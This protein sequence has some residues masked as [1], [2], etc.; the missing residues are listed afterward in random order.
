MAGIETIRYSLRNLMHR[1]ARSFLTVLSIFIGIATIFIFISFGLGLF[2]YINDMLMGSSAN[3]IIVQGKGFAAP[4]LDA[5]FKLDD[6]DLRAVENS[7]GVVEASGVYFKVAEVEFA[8][9]K[10]YAFV[11]GYDPKKPIIMDV[12]NVDIDEGRELN[13]GDNNKV[14]LGYNYLIKDR[15]FP[16][17]V[18]LNDKVLIQGIE[19]R[20]AGF[21][22]ELGNPQDDANIYVVD[23]AIDEIYP[24]ENSYGWI[25]AEVDPNKINWTI[26]NIEKELRKSRD[27][28]RGREDF[29]V[30]S[31]QDMIASYT[32]IL[33]IIIGFV[34]LI[35]LISVVVS[36]INTANT[37]ITSVIERTR[38]I[39][40]IKAIGARNR[41]IFGIFLF[42]SAFLGFIAGI[43]GVLLGW[44][45]VS[46][47]GYIL[48]VLGWGFL[49]PRYSFLFPYDIFIYCILFAIVTGAISGAIP[50]RSASKTNVVDALRYE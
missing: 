11:T 26:E 4:G 3:K 17:A 45:L 27:Q 36:A 7:L 47:G 25:I 2:G 10:K 6:G 16:R 40:V 1:K 48:N 12:F 41:E 8:D 29:F 33:N 37:M 44:A 28:E 13:D 15:I 43:I 32:S 5:S 50:A 49:T 42:E 20:V 21:Y 22:D 35:A 9:E 34:V 38:E 24:G 39:G 19:M 31:F 23:D 30:Q 18:R 14:V 46:L